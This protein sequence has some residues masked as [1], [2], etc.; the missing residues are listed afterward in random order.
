MP[1][2]RHDALVALFRDRPALTQAF[3]RD[4][5]HLPLPPLDHVH[6]ADSTLTDILPT[7][8]K[9]DLVLLF[10][11]SPGGPPQRAVVVEVQLAIDH[12]KRRSWWWYLVGVHTRHQCD[13]VLVVVTPKASVAA[14]ARTPI[15]LGHPD[16][17][18]RPI[19]IGPD[20]VPIVRDSAEAIQSPELAILSA[21]MHGRSDAGED[22]A[23]AAFAAI[24]GL[25]DERLTLY[26]DVLSESLHAAAQA[27]LKDLM[28]PHTYQYQSEFAKKYVAQGKAE[29]QSEGEARGRVEGEARGRALSVLAVLQARGMEVLPAARE[30]VLA[31]TD[32]SV[33]D[34][35]LARAVTAHAVSDVLPD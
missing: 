14:W 18:L 25:D 3:L 6:V 19:V 17:F 26:T 10:A 1:S 7:E 9:A 4:A 11:D 32:L 16:A 20:S 2:F 28:A 34:A 30:K 31:C 22:I 35:W 29:G 8:R 24:R 13:A 12:D 27:V 15:P 33:L 23:R 21:M 5:L